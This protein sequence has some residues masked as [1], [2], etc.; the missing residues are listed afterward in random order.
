MPERYIKPAIVIVGTLM[1]LSGVYELAGLWG[2][3]TAAGA[4][5]LLYGAL[6]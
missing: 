1:M 6:N 2:L 4:T 3:V 5:L